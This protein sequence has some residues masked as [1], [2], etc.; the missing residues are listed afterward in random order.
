MLRAGL[1]YRLACEATVQNT[2]P[3]L[4]TAGFCIRAPPGSDSSAVLSS[5]FHQRRRSKKP[6]A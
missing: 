6:K 4:F 1:E 5:R 3:E 2:A